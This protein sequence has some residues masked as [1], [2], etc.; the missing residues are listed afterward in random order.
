MFELIQSISVQAEAGR[1]SGK[2]SVPA[3][4]PLLADHFPG[5]P[6]L[7]GSFLVEL[8][9]Q[10][11]GPLAEEVVKLHHGFDRWA[12]PGMIRNLKFLGPSSLPSQLSISVAVLRH[13][14]SNVLLDVTAEQ[15]SELILR[16]ELVMMMIETSSAWDEA[17][18]ARNN[19][20]AKWKAAS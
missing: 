13:E 8:A 2:A 5:M 14:A 17:I 9:S 18:T 15:N 16:G 1:A 4:H 11:A 3:D 6:I 20:L 19:R 12:I 7:P 10:I